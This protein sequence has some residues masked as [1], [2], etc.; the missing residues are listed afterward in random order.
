MTY[1]ELRKQAAAYYQLVDR[2]RELGV[3]TSLDD[4]RSPKTLAGLGR[5]VRKAAV[6][7]P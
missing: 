3:P 6:R 7:E 1:G 5:A 4:P 2:A